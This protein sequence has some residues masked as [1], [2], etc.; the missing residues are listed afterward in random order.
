MTDVHTIFFSILLL[1]HLTHRRRF[2]LSHPCGHQV[3]H[4]SPARYHPHRAAHQRRRVLEQGTRRWH[5]V[6]HQYVAH[7]IGHAH[8]QRVSFTDCEHSRFSVHAYVKNLS[9]KYPELVDILVTPDDDEE[10]DDKKKRK[11]FYPEV[12][13]SFVVPSATLATSLTQDSLHHSTNPMLSWPR[14]SSTGV[15]IRVCSTSI[16]AI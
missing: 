9:D 7:L 5:R 12:R 8:K 15:S 2:V 13:I 3:V 14:G 4:F 10:H 6:P 11:R 16:E 1:L